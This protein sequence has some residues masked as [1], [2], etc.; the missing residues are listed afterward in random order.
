M[1][2]PFLKWAGGKQKLLPQIA[3]FLPR[4]FN[5]YHEPFL[6][7]GAMF[8]HLR[9]Q[10]LAMQAQLS[11]SN[12]EL[13]NAWRVVQGSPLKLIVALRKHDTAHRL[14]ADHYYAVRAMCPDKLEDMTDDGIAPQT[15]QNETK[16]GIRHY[17]QTKNAHRPPLT[18]QVENCSDDVAQAARTLYLNRT[19][20][21]G[22]YR[23]NRRGE[24]N[25]AK[26]SYTDPNVVNG[27]VIMA[28]HPL[29]KEVTITCADFRATLD[30]AN[31]SDFVYFD[32][33]Y[34]PT[35]ATAHFTG[36][37]P[38]GFA[39]SDQRDLA[40]LCRALDRRGVQWMVSNADAPLIRDLY[41]GFRFAEIEARRAIN[42]KVDKR[43]CVKE[44]IVTNY[45][46]SR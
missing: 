25:V 11:D 32:P 46:L 33:P 6:G 14:D 3:P 17:K 7:G 20:F 23:V 18:V 29:L 30:R 4:Q 36:Y 28:V 15:P 21:N 19:G 35:S 43:G 13:I 34:V 2:Q 9:G 24:F 12:A 5:V 16:I 10:G 39:E 44:V 45:D 8:L 31:A 1:T 41:R 37:T 26:G 22:L 40:A 42:C 27:E 38:N